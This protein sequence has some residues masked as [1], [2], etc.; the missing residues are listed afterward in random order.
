LSVT[1]FA[2]DRKYT[3]DIIE[4]TAQNRCLLLKE[5][6]YLFRTVIGD[7]SFEEGIHYWE[8]IADA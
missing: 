8:I 5:E 1:S 3:S 7:K 4:L 6:L 2:W